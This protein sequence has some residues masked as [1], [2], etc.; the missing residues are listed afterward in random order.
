MCLTYFLGFLVLSFILLV[1]RNSGE[2]M[3][4]LKIEHIKESS[5]FIDFVVKLAHE[6]TRFF[7]V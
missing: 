3:K 5:H 1:S 6:S 7:Y 4:F 2:G